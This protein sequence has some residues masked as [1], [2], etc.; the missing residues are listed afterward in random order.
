MEDYAFAF[1]V[2]ISGDVKINLKLTQ[3]VRLA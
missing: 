2:T 1:G 3:P